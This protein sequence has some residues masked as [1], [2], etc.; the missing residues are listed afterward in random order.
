MIKMMMV[1]QEDGTKKLWLMYI[2][3]WTRL[4]RWSRQPR[5]NLVN[6]RVV[7]CATSDYE[8][9][10]RISKSEVKLERAT[11]SRNTIPSFCINMINR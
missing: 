11:L 2:M 3:L 6:M 1:K 7:S 5:P 4:K 9:M 8:L 10:M